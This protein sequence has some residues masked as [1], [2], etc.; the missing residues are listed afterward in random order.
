MPPQA[1]HAP[2]PANGVSP[3][4]ASNSLK[5]ILGG[6]FSCGQCGRHHD[7][8]SRLIPVCQRRLPHKYLEHVEVSWW[9]RD[10]AYWAR[11]QWRE[12]NGYPTQDAL[13]TVTALLGQLSRTSV[14]KEFGPATLLELVAP[15][16]RELLLARH[17]RWR[18]DAERDVER[19]KAQADALLGQLETALP[20]PHPAG[21]PRCYTDGREASWTPTPKSQAELSRVAALFTPPMR[22]TQLGQRIALRAAWPRRHLSHQDRHQLIAKAF[23]AP[24]L[25]R[26][27]HKVIIID[28]LGLDPA[29]WESAEMTRTR[30]TLTTRPFRAAVRRETGPQLT[31]ALPPL[32][33][34]DDIDDEEV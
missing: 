34:P 17:A 5:A 13:Q 24:Y 11:H 16:A 2:P 4:A 6:A 19:A 29:F 23:S 3:D 27:R 12:H 14:H 25:S 21:P 8:N 15:D 32:F 10:H 18:S 20:P 28:G 26:R 33:D 9:L 30:F 1:G 31:L 7:P 22:T